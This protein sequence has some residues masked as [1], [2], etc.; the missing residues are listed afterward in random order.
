MKRK[1]LSV[2]LVF[3]LFFIAA[4]DK[5][6]SEDEGGVSGGGDEIN[7]DIKQE[8]FL[9]GGIGN[10]MT[11]VFADVRERVPEHLDLMK[12][13]I[14]DAPV[15]INAY[16]MWH[17]GADYEITEEV[18]N[19]TTELFQSYVSAIGLEVD[20]PEMD[21]SSP[22]MINTELDGIHTV[23]TPTSL[24]INAEINGIDME[25]STED[26]LELII[27][28]KYL[29]AAMGMLDLDNPHIEKQINYYGSG[30]VEFFIFENSDNP[31]EFAVNKNL[32]F[33]RISTAKELTSLSVSVRLADL[34]EPN[35]EIERVSFEVALARMLDENPDLDKEDILVCGLVYSDELKSG[36]RIPCYQFYIDR[37]E[38]DI[39]SPDE[40]NTGESSA[41]IDADLTEVLLYNVAACDLSNLG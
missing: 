31:V 1:L 11:D 15:Y 18:E 36:Y 17:G 29:S 27:D 21:D 22:W 12:N 24:S 37:G 16:P 14:S 25:S 13:E 38:A 34:Q 23:V 40:E 2:F 5:E 9:P 30:S 33:M 6:S 19:K 20:T 10:E 28:N 8:G 7:A 32:R 39:G 26:V 35:F 3:C 41:D 4:C